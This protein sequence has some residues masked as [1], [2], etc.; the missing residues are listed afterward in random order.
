[1]RAI[2]SNLDHKRGNSK[3]FQTLFLN[4]KLRLFSK[5]FFCSFEFQPY[6]SMTDNHN[7][8]KMLF[9][10]K[11]HSESRACTNALVIISYLYYLAKDDLHKWAEMIQWIEKFTGKVKLICNLNRRPAEHLSLVHSPAATA[12]CNSTRIK[13][14]NL[15]NL[16]IINLP[17]IA[18]KASSY[19]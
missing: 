16:H 7:L 2:T 13:S 17:A 3:Y 15:L 1:M 9:Q 14:E 18:W 12:A 4:N 5:F 19:H 10:Q 8:I 11:F 6:S